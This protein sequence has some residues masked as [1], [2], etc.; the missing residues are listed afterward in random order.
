MTY[1]IRHATPTVE[2]YRHLRTVTGMGA[3]SVEAVHRGL[4]N[5]LFAV[6][7]FDGDIPVAMG[8]I[9][10]D[11]GCFFQ[12]TDMAVEPAHQGKG[13]G[14]RIMG[15]LMA[16]LA[17][18][19]PDGGYVSLIADGRAHALYA[20]FGFQPTAPASIGMWWMAK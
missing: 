10:G 1:S 4:P 20:Q 5:T 12:V 2:T 15:E 8:R 17:D 3:K 6:Q 11:G 19:V 13:L 9:V 18:H 14:K 16:W 7:V